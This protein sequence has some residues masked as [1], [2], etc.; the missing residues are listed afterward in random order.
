MI[1]E[2]GADTTNTKLRP[3]SAPS[4]PGKSSDDISTIGITYLFS[5][6]KSNHLLCRHKTETSPKMRLAFYAKTAEKQV[7][8]S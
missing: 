2:A 5:G 7:V 4:A 8:M 1:F 3:M 6:C